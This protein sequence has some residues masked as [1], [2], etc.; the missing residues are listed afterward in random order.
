M[1]KH[2]TMR[3]VG[4]TLSKYVNICIMHT[5]MY[6]H[7]CIYVSMYPMYICIYVCIYIF[8]IIYIY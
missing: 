3:V 4:G 8:H 6:I 5:Y 1:R 7:V 2:E